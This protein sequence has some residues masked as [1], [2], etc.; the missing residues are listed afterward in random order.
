MRKIFIVQKIVAAQSIE[1]AMRIER[2]APVSEIFLDAEFRK[3]SLPEIGDER[4]I[5]YSHKDL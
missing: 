4:V 3:T 5:G 2:H 1:Q